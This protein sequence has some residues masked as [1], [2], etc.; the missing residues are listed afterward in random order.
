M[1]DAVAPHQ[2]IESIVVS[3]GRHQANTWLVG[4]TAEYATIQ[5]QRVLRG[6]LISSSDVAFGRSVIVLGTAASARLFPG[7]SAL[8]RTVRIGNQEFEVVGIQ[9]RRGKL[10]D[11]PTGNLDSRSAE[12]VLSILDRANEQGATIVMVTH[13]QDVAERAARIV[14]V[15]D[16][17]IVADEVVGPAVAAGAAR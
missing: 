8:G 9:D 7:E 3:A 11:E 2:D 12:E 5:N 4:M 16:G 17:L 15:G 13:S 14:R 10:A 6:R 1:V